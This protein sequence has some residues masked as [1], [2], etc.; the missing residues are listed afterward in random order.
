MLFAADDAR[1]RRHAAQ[2][3]AC[4]RCS[5]QIHTTIRHYRYHAHDYRASVARRRH[6]IARAHYA[7]RGAADI[8]RSRSV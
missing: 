6:D 1:A 3:A 5:A 7:R 4:A 8:T 2:R